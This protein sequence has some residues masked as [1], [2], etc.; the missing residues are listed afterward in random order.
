MSDQSCQSGDVFT[1]TNEEGF[2]VRMHRQ[3]AA[4]C[5]MIVPVSEA[6][7]IAGAGAG[8]SAGKT[9]RIETLLDYPTAALRAADPAYLGVTAG[10]FANRLAN[11]KLH[12]DGS[13]YPLTPTPGQQGHCLHGGA[14]G[15]SHRRW[16][17]EVSQDGRSV[18]FRLHSPSGDQGFPGN[19]DAQV[20]YTL[21]ERHTLQLVFE[22]TTDAPTVVNLAN[23]AYFNLNGDGAP[24]SNHHVWIDAASYTPVDERLIPTGAVASLSGTPL[25]LREPAELAERLVVPHEQL[26]RAGGFDHNYVLAPRGEQPSLAA[27]LWSPTSGLKLSLLTNQPGCQFYG[28]QHLRPPFAPGQGVCLEAQGFPDAPHHSAFPDATLRPDERYRRE[29]RYQFSVDRDD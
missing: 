15:F 27:S 6:G 25:D 8:A 23:H 19:L 13:V 14:R 4:L 11:A 16:Q 10:R 12:L 5:S 17:V 21:L 9:E 26:S 24:A 22:A 2:E 29:T 28:G 1:L 20:T 7:S 3:G 18:V